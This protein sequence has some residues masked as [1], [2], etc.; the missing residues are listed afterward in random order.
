MAQVKQTKVR[1]SN[2]AMP[3][4]LQAPV[5][6]GIVKEW[7]EFIL[8]FQAFLVMK[9]CSEMIQTNFKSRLHAMEDEEWMP[10]LNWEK[11]RT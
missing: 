10:V 6:N 3:I 8:M 1:M 7:P 11:Q 4:N 9:G 5:F 2:N